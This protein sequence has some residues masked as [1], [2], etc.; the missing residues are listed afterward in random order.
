MNRKLRAKN[1][2]EQ[3]NIS[4]L[5]EFE[6]VENR[7]KDLKQR[8]VSLTLIMLGILLF[9]VTQYHTYSLI[10]ILLTHSISAEV[11]SFN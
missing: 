4:P 5:N 9:C 10:F 2:F 8:I 3:R 7:Q 1:L 6:H 11:F